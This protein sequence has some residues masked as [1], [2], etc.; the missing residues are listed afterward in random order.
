M[1]LHLSHHTPVTAGAP[2]PSQAH[3]NRALR[4]A[5][6]TALLIVILALTLVVIAATGAGVVSQSTTPQTLPLPAAE[7][8]PT[9]IWLPASGDF[10][11][12]HLA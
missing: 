10:A 5:L 6:A 4:M 7:Q 8:A 11:T 3:G 1:G 9:T 12:R 2:H